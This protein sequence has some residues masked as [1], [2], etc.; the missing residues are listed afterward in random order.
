MR[1][2]VIK[3]TTPGAPHTIVA[4]GLCCPVATDRTLNAKKQ[5]L[6]ISMTKNGPQEYGFTDGRTISWP[7]S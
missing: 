2:G 5:K 6:V 3:H 1:K 4:P 7:E